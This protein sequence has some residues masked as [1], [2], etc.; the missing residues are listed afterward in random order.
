MNRGRALKNP[1]LQIGL[2]VEGSIRN[3]L[4]LSFQLRSCLLL[5][6]QPVWRQ[7]CQVGD[8]ERKERRE[9]KGKGGEKGEEERGEAR[10][11]MRREG[12][13]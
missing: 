3:P 11:N 6:L 10:E 1:D 9:G 13:E 2:Q 7:M 4:L 12:R 8:M 5:A